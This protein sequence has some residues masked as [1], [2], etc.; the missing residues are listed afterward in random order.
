MLLPN[1]RR[2]SIRYDESDPESHHTG[3]THDG[4]QLK[5]LEKLGPKLKGIG[6]GVVLHYPGITI[7]HETNFPS[8]SVCKRGSAISRRRWTGSSGQDWVFKL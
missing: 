2:I 4:Q 6:M 8:F 1:I 3:H 7:A 5:E